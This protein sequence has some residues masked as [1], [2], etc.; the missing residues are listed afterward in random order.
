MRKFRAIAEGVEFCCGFEEE[1]ER[2]EDGHLSDK[3]H[4]RFKPIRPL[5]KHN[6]RQIIAEG[7]LLPVNK[8][9][10]RLNLQRIAYDRCAAMGRRPQ[11]DDVRPEAY[12]TIVAIR[13]AMGEGD[14]NGHA[15]GL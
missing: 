11:P 9:L 14:M 5:N 12:D 7:I 13:R 6:A 4:L 3:F 15:N 2:I 1:V 10:L 8:I